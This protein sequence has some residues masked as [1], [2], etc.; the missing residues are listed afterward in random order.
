MI[1][2]SRPPIKSVT[3]I[4]NSLR[5]TTKTRLTLEQANLHVVASTEIAIPLASMFATSGTNPSEMA[6]IRARRKARA[7]PTS[8]PRKGAPMQEKSE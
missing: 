5:I 6:T 8:N 7:N 2:N 4:V 1:C 3:L